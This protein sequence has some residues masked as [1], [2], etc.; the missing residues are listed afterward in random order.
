MILYPVQGGQGGSRVIAAHCSS[1]DLVGDAVRVSGD[2]VTGMY[3]VSKVDIDA[4]TGNEAVSMGVIISKSSSVTCQV[5]WRGVLQGIYSGLTPGSR[6]FVN[7][8]SRLQEGPPARPATGRRLV[9][10]L[11]YVL[12]NDTILIKPLSPIRA[13][14]P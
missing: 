4:V 14:A 9:Q 1:S 8:L 11:A 6:L 2:R 13:V 7:E 10:E 5:Q 12:A 3:T